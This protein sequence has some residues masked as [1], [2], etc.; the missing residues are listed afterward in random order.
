MEWMTEPTD[1]IAP[2]TAPAG[3]LHR[4]AVLLLLY[5]GPAGEPT[6][7]FVRRTEH[8]SRHQGQIGLPGGRWEPGD[9]SLEATALRE[10]RE[11]LAIDP[12]D[13]EVLGELGQF[14]TSVTG[15]EVVPFVAVTDRRPAFRPD[16][17]EVA[18]LLEVPL[19]HLEAAANWRSEDWELP[20]GTR[21]VD[22]V[23]FAG[24]VIWGL[25]A[26]IVR[27]FL[28]SK[29]REHARERFRERVSHGRPGA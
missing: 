4:A 24:H 28:D 2:P 23:D 27:A 25:T 22:F 20:T 26:R 3:G 5:P 13:C 6:V 8:L 7:P 10:A 15:Y 21:R 1:P 16:P 12:A 29:V 19:D 17:Y 11:E 14:S 9:G 18:E